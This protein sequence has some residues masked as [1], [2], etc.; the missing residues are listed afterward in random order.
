LRDDGIR[1]QNT[2][3]PYHQVFLAAQHYDAAPQPT[4][5]SNRN[6]AAR[7][8]PLSMDGFGNVRVGVIMIHEKNGRGRQYILFQ[9]DMVS[10]RNRGTAADPATRT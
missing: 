1:G 10:C 6:A 5:S 9:T 8:D 7:R 2:V 4:V 3:P